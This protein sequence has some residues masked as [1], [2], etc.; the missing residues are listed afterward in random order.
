MGSDFNG[1]VPGYSLRWAIIGYSTKI[2]T[3]TNLK[4][5]KYGIQPFVLFASLVG[6]F[7]MPEHGKNVDKKASVQYIQNTVVYSIKME[8]HDLLVTQL[9]CSFGMATLFF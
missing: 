8:S 6:P 5:T 7:R 2:S 4:L 9:E 1:R 3:F